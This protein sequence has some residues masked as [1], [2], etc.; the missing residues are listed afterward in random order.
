MKR[1]R[2]RAALRA[3]AAVGV[4]AIA[5]C[6]DSQAGSADGSDGG[7]GG[8]GNGDGD[9]QQT[10][11]NATEGGSAGPVDLAFH[12]KVVAADGDR[13]DNFGRAVAVDG[14]TAVITAPRDDQPNGEDGGSAY[15]FTKSGGGWRQE[16]KIAATEGES[17][18]RFGSSV[19]ISGDTAVVGAALADG[20]NGTDSGSVAV[21]ERAS[22]DWPQVSTLVA[23]DG[24][25]LDS[26]GDAVALEGDTLVVG[27]PNHPGNNGTD[28]GGV[29]IFER[30]GD[31]WSQ[32]A[33]LAPFVLDRAD[34]F[35]KALGL[36]GDTLLVGA[37]GDE[38][39]NGSQ[40]GAVYPYR[41]VNGSWE[42]QGR[43]AAE[44]GDE[45]HDFGRA[46]A[47]NGDRAVI[48]APGYETDEDEDDGETDLGAAYV[49][50]RI[51]GSWTQQ[52]RLRPGDGDGDDRF[53][54]AVALVDDVA[55]AGA[56][57]DE[58]PNGLLGGSAYVFQLADGSWSQQAKFSARHGRPEDNFGWSIAASQ[59]LALAGVPRED[60]AQG[61]S[62]GAAHFYSLF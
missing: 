12:E 51:E 11:E 54:Y 33:K 18:D 13:D 39:P 10:A 57:R 9:G 30:A 27:A 48:G 46:V 44:G 43:I 2:R 52:A 3:L 31:T 59:G 50:D 47:S 36:V 5:G 1:L 25:R 17:D 22:G 32:Q 42:R 20:P 37:P 4:G 7:G 19:A 14:D 40:A 29:Y 16:A 53:G 6:N 15:V 62:A 34:L 61:H 60:R 24:E 55:L 23:E 38:D 56:P 26:F 8:G 41:R 21:F 35:G 58:D 45:Y 28:A 49:F